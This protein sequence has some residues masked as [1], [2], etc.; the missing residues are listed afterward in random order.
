[1]TKA[2][3]WRTV[4]GFEH[5]EVSDDGQLR[6]WRRKA[7]KWRK[8]QAKS[9]RRESPILLNPATSP[10]GYRIAN[11]TNDSA[12]RMLGVHRLVAIAFLGDPPSPD[13]T[14]VAHND[15]NPSNNHVSN[16]RWATHQDNQMD[17]RKHKTMQDGERCIT[18][19]ITEAMALEIARRA[20]VR[21]QGVVLAREFG[22]S[23]AQISR[24]KNQRRWKYLAST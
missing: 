9:N 21:G 12:H 22:L 7:C 13:H 17:M 10:R 3:E 15:G 16:L 23:K 19:K 1:M 6:S 4:R 5:Y 20:Q 11:L 8:S 14:D 2:P 24:I 18:A